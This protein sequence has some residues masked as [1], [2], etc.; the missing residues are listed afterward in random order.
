MTFWLPVQPCLAWYQLTIQTD[1]MTK[2]TLSSRAKAAFKQACSSW[3]TSGHN[4][5]T[6]RQNHQIYTSLSFQAFHQACTT[7]LHNV[8]A[9]ADR[10]SCQIYT[11]WWKLL[12]SQIYTYW[13]KLLQSQTVATPPPLPDDV[14]DLIN[15]SNQSALASLF[16]HFSHPSALGRLISLLSIAETKD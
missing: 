15:L 13:W 3:V 1:L 16:L 12:Q 8:L 9:L 10:T 11:Y 14:F 7:S 2:F 6:G 5:L 4:I